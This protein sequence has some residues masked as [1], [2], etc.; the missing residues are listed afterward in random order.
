[1][2]VERRLGRVNGFCRCETNKKRAKSKAHPQKPR[3]GHPKLS[4]DLSSGPPALTTE[5]IVAMAD[6]QDL[7]NKEDI[8]ALRAL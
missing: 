1:M 7:Q 2:R 3:V 4:Y 5:Q 8:E 6:A